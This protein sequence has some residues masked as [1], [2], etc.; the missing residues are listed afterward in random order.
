MKKALWITFLVALMATLTPAA[1]AQQNLTCSSDNG[2][3]N[4]CSADTRGGVDVI[5]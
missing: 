4:Y 3:R 5:A 1:K 2:K